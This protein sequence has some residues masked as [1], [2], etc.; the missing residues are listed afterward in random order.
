MMLLANKLTLHT[1]LDRK[2]EMMDLVT[3]SDP[4]NDPNGKRKMNILPLATTTSTNPSPKK[5]KVF[6]DQF[7][8]DYRLSYSYSGDHCW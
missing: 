7:F 6:K 8:V 2:T 3:T 4:L 5:L 1:D